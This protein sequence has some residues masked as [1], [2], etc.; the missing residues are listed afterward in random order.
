MATDPA[1]LNY[2]SFDAELLAKIDGTKLSVG[3]HNP[4]LV[5]DPGLVWLVLK[6][7]V[8]IYAVPL[9][10]GAVAGTGRHLLRVEAGELIFGMPAIPDDLA[11]PDGSRREIGLRAVAVMGTELF[12]AARR[13]L[14]QDDFDLIVVDWIDRWLT[15]ISEII[16]PGAPGGG[17]RPTAL[18][19]A[20]PEIP[21]AAGA[22]LVPQRGDVI[23]TRIEQGEAQI[24]DDAH[25]TLAAGGA[26]LPMAKNMWL[27]CR[28]ECVVSAVYTPTALFRG[29]L[30]DNL[31]RFHHMVVQ[32]VRDSRRTHMRLETA[33]LEAKASANRGIFRSAL[34]EIGGVLMGGEALVTGPGGDGNALLAAMA[35]VGHA[36]GIRITAPKQRDERR[37]ETPLADIARHS[38]IRVRRVVL[39][40]EWYRRDNGPLLGFLGPE[41]QPVALLPDGIDAYRMNDPATGRIVRVTDSIAGELS[42]EAYVLYRPFPAQ[43]LTLRSLLGF[44]ARGLKREFQITATMGILAGLVALA[45][46]I[47]TGHLFSSV[48]PRADIEMHLMIIAGLVLAAFGTAAF[49]VTRSFAMLRIQTRMDSSIQTAVWDRL[50]ALPIPFFRQYSSG[51]LADRAN[52]INAIREVM[53][54]TVMQA[55]LNAI[56]S[57]FSL[58]LLFWYSWKLAVV[59]M[60]VVFVMLALS[61]TLL[62]V[63]IP[64]QRRM[65]GLS[66]RIEGLVFQLLTGISKLRISGSEARAFAR[67]SRE[68]TEVNRINYTLRKFT[69][70]QEV[71]VGVFPVAASMILFAAIIL[72]LDVPET[73]GQ[74]RAFGIGQFLAFNAA[75]GQFSMAMLSLLGVAGTLVAVVPLYERIKPILE[76]LPE[77][78]ADKA[79]P[80]AIDG[81][82]EFSRIVFHYDA[83]APAVIDDVSLKIDSGSYVAFVGASGSGKST[84]V[85]LLL[86]FEQPQSGGVYVDGKDLSGLDMMAVRRQIGVVLQ[87]G[88]IMAGTIFDNIVGSLPLT[89]DDAWE[90]ARMAGFAQDVEQMPMGM[91]T[92]LSD[93]AGTLSGGQ[94]QRLMIARALVHKPRILILDEATS[95]LDNQ[96]QAVVN[97]S[98]A[99]MNMTRLVVAHRLS[100]IENVDRIFVMRQ[101]RVVESGDFNSLMALDGEFADLARRQII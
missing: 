68:F 64:H 18:L 4:F 25:L 95:A 33:R 37:L 71:L 14:E 85:R 74:N 30:W 63:Q 16:A 26:L 61:M 55:G 43:A 77:I 17:T 54:G 22:V 76:S 39:L 48:V 86:G 34:T 81:D 83:T 11:A 28:E 49:T 9:A 72:M 59:A 93:G 78:T 41:K 1:E 53:T 19:E 5:S 20:E 87:N 98:L 35:V 65:V 70:L 15:Q 13:D 82:I 92:L 6:G 101:G 90:A 27:T 73:A 24:L 3:Y 2:D 60:G 58:A 21:Q 91:H 12:R 80:G 97:A 10:D 69:A 46:P 100:T 23:W 99:K 8:D 94:R 67:W 75:F 31:D 96:T 32:I 42:G 7:S 57:L 29:E 66:G 51:D 44:G 89:L 45:T 52:G 84:L 56:F 88:R 40:E 36:A 50:L 62:L 38:H 47:A 79:D